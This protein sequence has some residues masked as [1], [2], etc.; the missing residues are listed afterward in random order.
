MGGGGRRR[1]AR[2]RKQEESEESSQSLTAE[3]D[4]QHRT[5]ELLQSTDVEMVQNT[6]EPPMAMEA[7]SSD[8]EMPPSDPHKFLPLKLSEE[9]TEGVE[10]AVRG[11]ESSGEGSVVE[12]SA[13]GS[14]QI[15]PGVSPSGAYSQFDGKERKGSDDWFDE[16][17]QEE[18]GGA[19]EEKRKDEDGGGVVKGKGAAMPAGVSL[20]HL[21]KIDR[22]PENLEEPTWTYLTPPP[23]TP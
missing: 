20:L 8:T 15:G 1:T 3:D 21:W 13:S 18:E 5:D 19:A 17:P 4:L 22:Q 11:R 6:H 7:D 14:A 12:T 16:G 23:H 9:D 2:E 10:L